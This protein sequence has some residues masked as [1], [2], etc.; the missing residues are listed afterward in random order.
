M[1][2]ALN[3]QE[4]D[5]VPY[6]ADFTTA[7]GERLAAYTGVPDYAQ[8]MGAHLCSMQYSGWPACIDPVR[9]LFRDDF[10]VCWDRSGVD[11]DIGV[12]KRPVIPE[13]DLSLW[14]EPALDE[15]RLRREF[16][17]TLAYRGDRFTFAGIG[18]SM[19]ERAWSLCG[20]EDALVYMLLEPDFMHG[21]LDAICDYNLK[22]IGIAA[23]YDF[24]GFYFGDD[25][26]QQKGLIMGP[27]NWRTFIKPRMARMYA[28][29]KARGWRVLQHSCGDIAELFP[30]LIDIG[31]DCYQTFQP[32]IYNIEAVKREYGRDLTFWGGIS[33]QRLLPY[34]APDEVRRQTARI[35]RIMRSGGGYIAAP[36]HAV[37]PDVPPENITAMFDVFVNQDRYL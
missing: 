31:L 12:I 10:G 9:E 22:I 33:T 24:D 37:P 16:E 34:A 30:D 29:V 32:E 21:L 17:E 27:Q 25:W 28:A 13:P 2:A 4:T 1:R 6:H 19:F 5:V 23:E 35:M 14:R 11:K 20:M 26:G 15:A 7:E 18:F 3:H 36:T 8:Q